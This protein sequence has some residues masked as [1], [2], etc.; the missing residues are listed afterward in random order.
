MSHHRLFHAQRL[1]PGTRVDLSGEQAHYLS[2]VLRLKPGSSVR[3]FDATGVEYQCCVEKVKR[4][5]VAL[6]VGNAIATNPESPLDAWLVQSV[7]RGERMDYCVQKATELGVKRILP[8]FA[9]R[10]VVRLTDERARKR[11]QHWQKVAI[12]ACEQSGRVRPPQISAPLPLHA[13]LDGQIPPAA[14][15]IGLQPAATQQTLAEISP[16]PHQPLVMFVGPEGGFDDQEQHIL[17]SR[18]VQLVALGPRVLRS[19]TAGIVAL[20]LCQHL[21]GDLG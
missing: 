8:V 1:I 10:S 21:W 5:R 3:L 6:H 2:T 17:T 12:S 4:K 15:L 9:N 14:T 18:G 11:Q 7:L 19:E 16:T 20:T 13:A